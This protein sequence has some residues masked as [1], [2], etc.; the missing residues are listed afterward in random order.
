MA[1]HWAPETRE[2][3]IGVLVRRVPAKAPMMAPGTA[4][5]C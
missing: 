3:R 2:K 5:V 1:K 4:G